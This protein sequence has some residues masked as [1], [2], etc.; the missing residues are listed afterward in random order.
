MAERRAASGE[1][2][3]VEQ[4]QEEMVLLHARLNAERSRAAV[5][6]ARK[7]GQQ[8]PPPPPAEPDPEAEYEARRSAPSAGA[9]ATKE[10][11][12]RGLPMLPVV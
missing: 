9:G 7:S 6:R 8:A 10:R 4:L 3:S 1:G 12:G 2:L 5:L 11:A